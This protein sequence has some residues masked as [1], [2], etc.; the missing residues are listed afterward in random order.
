[1]GHTTVSA[2]KASSVTLNFHHGAEESYGNVASFNRVVDTKTS[3]IQMGPNALN[4]G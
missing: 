3:R 2:T 1:M 4:I